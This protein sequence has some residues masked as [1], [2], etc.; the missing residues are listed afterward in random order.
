MVAVLSVYIIKTPSSEAYLLSEVGGV[1]VTTDAS[2]AV[3]HDRSVCRDIL[4]VGRQLRISRCISRRLVEAV[5]IRQSQN[6]H[7]HSLF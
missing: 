4:Q 5:L 2:G 6:K 3:H 7:Q 1:D